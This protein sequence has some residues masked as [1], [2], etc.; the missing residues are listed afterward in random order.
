MSGS[1]LAAVIHVDLH[2]LAVRLPEGKLDLRFWVRG[3]ER[4]EWGLGLRVEGPGIRVQGRDF[5][6]QGFVSCSSDV[7]YRVQGS[8]I[9]A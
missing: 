4:R 3:L 1:G 7:G 2:G 9:E 8:G 6:I 5:R